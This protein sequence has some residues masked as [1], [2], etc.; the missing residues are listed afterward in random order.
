MSDAE[1]RRRPE[2]A[3]REPDEGSSEQD[4]PDE[5][6][7]PTKEPTRKPAPEESFPPGPIQYTAIA[8]VSASNAEGETS[9]RAVV[10]D[11]RKAVEEFSGQFSGSQMPQALS[12]EYARADLP[13]DEVMLGAV[14]DVSCQ[15]P[16]DLQVEKTRRG[17]AI[18]M[19]SRARTARGRSSQARTSGDRR[20]PPRRRC[21]GRGCAALPGSRPRRRPWR[22]RRAS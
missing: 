16:T 2:E 5:T 18:T 11:S 19:V 22:C 17:V 12:K 6:T 1:S 20:R 7:E 9:P 21:I 4:K 14:V 13:K 3:G 15:A 10:L 8:L